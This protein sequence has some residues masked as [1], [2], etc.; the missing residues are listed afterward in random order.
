VNQNPLVEVYRGCQITLEGQTY[1]AF[2][3]D[4]EVLIGRAADLLNIHEVVDTWFRTA[5]IKTPPPPTTGFLV[6]DIVTGKLHRGEKGGEMVV[7]KVTPG[8]QIMVRGSGKRMMTLRPHQII[9]VKRKNPV[10]A[11]GRMITW[12]VRVAHPGAEGL[13]EHL[14]VGGS[15]DEAVEQVAR[16]IRLKK[17]PAGEVYN[18]G[19]AREGISYAP[20]PRLSNPMGFKSSKSVGKSGVGLAPPAA[21]TPSAATP[22]STKSEQKEPRFVL[23][24]VNKEKTATILIRRDTEPKTPR[25]EASYEGSKPLHKRHVLGV[26][27]TTDME[28][29]D[30]DS[31]V[32]QELPMADDA[33]F[34]SDE[35][36]KIT[37]GKQIA[38]LTDKHKG[39]IIM[40]IWMVT[41]RTGRITT[42]KT[43]KGLAGFILAKKDAILKFFNVKNL[44]PR[45]MSL[46]R[47]QLTKEV[48]EW[49]HYNHRE[50]Y[51]VVVGYPCPTCHQDV[52]NA[53]TNRIYGMDAA[54][55]EGKRLATA[56]SL[57]KHLLKWNAIRSEHDRI[58]KVELEAALKAKAS[59]DRFSSRSRP[60]STSGLY[61]K[62]EYG[63]WGSWSGED[64]EF[65]KWYKPSPPAAGSAASSAAV[66]TQTPKVVY[67]SPS[68]MPTAVSIPFGK[69][70]L[71]AQDFEDLEDIVKRYGATPTAKI[72][73]RN[74]LLTGA[75]AAEVLSRFAF[76]KVGEDELRAAHLRFDVSPKAPAAVPAVVAPVTPVKLPPPIHG[77]ED[78]LFKDLRGLAV[79]HSSSLSE[80][81][82][83][84]R[85]FTTGEDERNLL[86][87]YGAA[88][89]PGE[90]SNVR[91]ALRA[92][93]IRYLRLKQ[94][95]GDAGS[96]ERERA[97]VWGV[98]GESE[99]AAQVPSDIV[100]NDH[101]P[102][103]L[104]VELPEAD[105]DLPPDPDR[106]PL[107]FEEDPSD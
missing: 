24:K 15:E 97:R 20:V 30:K 62:Y 95:G 74:Y 92:G 52:T 32:P 80:E 31:A 91:V 83:L 55:S 96:A 43:D 93:R 84:M 103:M 51:S 33:F 106:R 48:V 45:I 18:V 22:W 105:D 53:T 65:G 39:L 77:R 58:R 67:Q 70:G 98:P 73:I 14:V 60:Y 41:D 23:V 46:S 27:V 76:S 12:S 6:G 3:P 38:I 88:A 37:M 82:E 9:L 59:A 8:G 26:M 4:D 2:A 28:H 19:I 99:F 47:E 25:D 89:P 10:D 78:S 79:V 75:R 5:A 36:M 29:A 34:K 50:N 85:Y 86:E 16:D 61:G 71:N 100:V 87:R 94:E 21:A 54:E 44:S 42:K 11:H 69:R 101:F 90:S 49:D 81:N 102:I 35:W 107:D 72:L 66:F 13:M 68:T 63:D 56:F 1:S 17:I 104:D 57:G 40:P 64:E 7:T